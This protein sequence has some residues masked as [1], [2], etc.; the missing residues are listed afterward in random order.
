LIELISRFNEMQQSKAIEGR[1]EGM[2]LLQ[3]PFVRSQSS[4]VLE[5]LLSLE[6]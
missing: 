5:I 2:L 1:L 6:N 3:S 4:S